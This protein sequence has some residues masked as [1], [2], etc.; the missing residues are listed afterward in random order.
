MRHW[1]VFGPLLSLILSAC[2]GLAPDPAAVSAEGLPVV[3]LDQVARTRR[4]AQEQA[5]VEAVAL[6][7]YAKAAAAAQAA[8]AIDPRSAR[9]HAVLGMAALHEA[10][11]VDPIEWHGLRQGES[12]LAI[13]R[14][15]AP[16]DAVVGRLHATFLR[17]CGHLSAAAAAAEDALVRCQG[18]PDA[19][20]AALLGVAGTYRYELGEERAAYPYLQ[21]YTALR[22]RD[23]TAHY[24]LGSSLLVI[25]KSPPAAPAS[26]RRAQ[27]DAEQAAAAFRRCAE[28]TPSDEGAS[29]AIASAKLRAAELARLRRDGDSGAREAEAAELEQQA[30]DHLRLVAE[31]F[32][33]S[34]EARFRLGATASLLGDL[35][36]A[37]SS[38]QASLERDPAHAGSLMNLAA[39]AADR[40]E[41][42]LTRRLL[43]RL[44]A[45]DES[46]RQLTGDERKRIK[47]WLE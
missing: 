18:A 35:A 24:R 23:A 46:R 8:L 6:E 2:A 1:C 13:A 22:P 33:G 19:E 15:L 32:P 44:L 14:E 7:Q 27:A 28:L 26:Y 39:L 30:L 20:L 10:S 31:R 40:G 36:L 43:L 29:L 4:E 21:A 47:A 17:K 16:A 12:S 38:Y 25:A 41:E 5:A 34:A 42:E 11:S 9:A 3:E 37:R 45:A